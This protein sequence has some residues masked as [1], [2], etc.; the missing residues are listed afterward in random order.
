MLK[1]S[2]TIL[3]AR[4]IH[5][6]AV[7]GDG[8]A[9]MHAD[10]KRD[11]VRGVDPALNFLPG[12]LLGSQLACLVFFLNPKL[13]FGV[14]AF[15]RGAFVYGGATGLVTL[16][17]LTP[18]TRKRERRSRRVFPWALALTLAASA[19]VYWF[20]ASYYSFF[21]PPGMNA[22]L[23]KAAGWLTLL[24]LV[25]FYTA[26]VHTVQAR[27]YSRRT[28]LFLGF[29][30]VISLYVLVERRDAFKP[31]PQP[32]LPSSV[33]PEMRPLTIV[34]GLDGATMDAILPLAR[35][36]QL[37][38][39]AQLLEDGVHG[40]LGGLSPTY[41][42]ALWSTIATGKLPYEH[43]VLGKRVFPAGFLSPGDDLRLVPAGF[44]AQVLRT[45]GFSS[46]PPDATTK[47]SLVLWEILS[48][49]GVRSG[50]IGWPVSHPAGE[51]IEFAFSPRYFEGNYLWAR[52]TPSELV[53]RGI[54]FKVELEDIDLGV[55]ER[56]GVEVP[57]E[58][59]K[60]LAG[61]LWKES[62]TTF[63]MDQK[64]D[65]QAWFVRLP[66]L[67]EVSRRYFGSF[68]AV[69]FEGA[70]AP[71]HDQSAQFVTAYY[72]HLDAYLSELWQRVRGP[73]ILAVVSAY[74][75]E[76]PTGIR[77]FLEN[78]S[79][80]P[81]PGR[82]RGAPD[83]V[84]FL[85]GSGI[86]GGVQ[87]EGAG[88][89]DVLPTLLYG[90]RLPVAKDLDGRV[91]VDAFEEGFLAGHPLTFVPSYETLAGRGDPSPPETPESP[92]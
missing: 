58:V 11:L 77:R 23:I 86:R 33:A 81:L 21:V 4:I 54:L 8:Q 79:G 40:R 52:A 31:M 9:T 48:R 63:L 46:K 72:R 71:I 64:Q 76:A 70:Q 2:A 36:G 25:V 6:R 15:L 85:A 34:V 19:G 60:A 66:G 17:I 41:P 67:A 43:G 82:F 5:Q 13:S 16:L 80:K 75:V 57:H 26:L 92:G 1:G 32:A 90:L 61:D 51:D 47:D 35:Q 69:Q 18:F 14:A 50:V 27:P 87:L 39:F 56:L 62:L 28:A 20:H 74:G 12:F 91:L 84:L 10:L 24:A 83:G 42:E 44:G 78:V 7:P 3:S 65:V 22:R 53:E 88:L 68:S 30:A 55:T 73:R 38:F 37:P 59:L 29:V 45:A 49:L 89:A